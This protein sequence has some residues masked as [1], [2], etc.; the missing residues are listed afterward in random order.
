MATPS[1][2]NQATGKRPTPERIFNALNAYEDTAVLKTAIEL[3]G[4]AGGFPDPGEPGPGECDGR[5]R[6]VV[7]AHDR[8][9]LRNR[10]S[11]GTAGADVDVCESGDTDGAVRRA[12]DFAHG[13][14]AARR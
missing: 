3:C 11:A 2:M 5:V 7:D 6:V 13:R 14:V 9:G 10:D 4:G 8:R 1:P 12:D